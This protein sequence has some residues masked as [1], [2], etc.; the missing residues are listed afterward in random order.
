MLNLVTLTSFAMKK[1]ILSLFI[2][3]FMFLQLPAQKLKDAL[4]LSNGSVIYGKLLEIADDKYK[5][6]TSD[7]SLFVYSSGEVEKFIKESPGFDRRKASG[8]GMALEA[9]VLVGSQSSQLDAPFSFNILINYTTDTKNILSFGS[10]VEFLGSS[11]TPLFLEYKRLFSDRKATPFV[12][13]RGGGLVHLGDEDADEGSY[14]YQ[15][16][17]ARDYKGGASLGFGTG[18]SWAGEE[19]ETYLSFGYRYA[20]TSYKQRDY[21]DITYT[22]KNNYHRLEI[23]F[24]FKF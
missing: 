12:F 1:S 20:R 6:Q 22:Y 13:F 9:G 5:I 17:Y 24:G 3:T 23:K 15:Y 18:I 2:L 4:Y 7:G 10:G 16:N 14:P 8:I 19:S 11:F 21:N